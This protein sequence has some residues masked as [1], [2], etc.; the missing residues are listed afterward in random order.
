MITKTLHRPIRQFPFLRLVLLV[1]VLFTQTN[2]FVTTRFYFPLRTSTPYLPANTLSPSVKLYSI[3][4]ST[5]S[6]LTT[7]MFPPIPERQIHHHGNQ[8]EWGVSAL[9]SRIRNQF[10]PGF[11][12]SEFMLGFRYMSQRFKWLISASAIVHLIRAGLLLPY[13]G[14]AETEIV[15]KT[16]VTGFHAFESHFKQILVGA[17]PVPLQNFCFNL[18]LCPIVEEITYRGIVHS[19][20]QIRF[21]FGLLYSAFMVRF[22][23]NVVYAQIALNALSLLN[24]KAFAD[25]RIFA[26]W[27]FIVFNVFELLVSLVPI[28][29]LIKMK[30]AENIGKEDL[31]INTTEEGG[32]RRSFSDKVVRT[33]LNNS[34]VLAP[35]DIDTNIQQSL[36]LGARVSGAFHFGLAHMSVGTV[37]LPSGLRS[38][39]KGIGTFVS[40]MLVES[41]LAVLRKNLWAPIGAHMAYNMF[42][43]LLQIIF[44]VLF[45]ILISSKKL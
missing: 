38:I 39:Q 19:L 32:K 5:V 7:K 15:V 30:Q 40:S 26:S 4:K 18:L 43:Q 6:S 17:I 24:L 31:E 1:N 33:A 14:V 21:Q 27:V 3:K 8:T 12:R 42:A 16:F 9:R 10:N 28:P 41:R 11:V 25:R 35:L 44:G 36:L 45:S 20:W 13:H 37:P 29:Q 22:N 2:G 23:A 34:T